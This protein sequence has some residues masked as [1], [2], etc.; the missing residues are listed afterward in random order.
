MVGSLLRVAKARLLVV[1]R[2]GRAAMS[3]V[4]RMI[5]L[6]ARHEGLRVAEVVELVA[7]R[8]TVID[9]LHCRYVSTRGHN[10]RHD[11]AER[12]GSWRIGHAQVKR[13]SAIRLGESGG[14][15]YGF[16]TLFMLSQTHGGVEEEDPTKGKKGIS[17]EIEGNDGWHG[18]ASEVTED[19]SKE[20]FFPRRKMGLTVG[21]A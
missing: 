18:R 20:V 4:V 7:G 6:G 12:Q 8:E 16:L 10:R 21:D 19:E 17:G 9:V 3:R 14:P 11:R 1:G 15:I 2:C 13:S 5:L